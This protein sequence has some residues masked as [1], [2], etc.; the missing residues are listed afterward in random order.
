[1]LDHEC[2]HLV[3]YR[4]YKL[5]WIVGKTMSFLKTF[6]CRNAIKSETAHGE[7]DNALFPEWAPRGLLY[8]GDALGLGVLQKLLCG[9]SFPEAW[10][11]NKVDAVLPSLPGGTDTSPQGHRRQTQILPLYSLCPLEWGNEPPQIC[12][13]TWIWQKGKKINHIPDID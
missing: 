9:L 7:Q 5:V 1:M 3:L 12:F 8:W 4:S 6:W 2:F 10:S 11:S 13:L